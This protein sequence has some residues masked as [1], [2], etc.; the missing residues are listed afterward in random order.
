MRFL[1]GRHRLSSLLRCCMAQQ[2]IGRTSA[3]EVQVSGA[4]DISH[5]ET[6][7]G[8]G[9]QITAGEQAVKI[10]LQRGGS[11]RLCSTSYRS[12]GEGPLHRRPGQQRAHDGARSRRHRS[13]LRR[14]QILRCLAYPRPA[15]PHLRSWASRPEHPG[16]SQ[17]RYLRRQSRRRCALRHRDQ[18]TG[19]WSVPGHARSARQ[20]P[21]WQPERGGGS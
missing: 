14:R 15:H 6:M 9:S 7:L 1:P 3:T 18:P 17:G 8:N 4:V 12:P 2:P 21:A 11:L 16:K 13:Q 20:F 19:R 10:A 5:G